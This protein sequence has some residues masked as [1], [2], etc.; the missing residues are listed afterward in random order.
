MTN[1]FSFSA[2]EKLDLSKPDPSKKQVSTN[3]GISPILLNSSLQFIESHLKSIDSSFIGFLKGTTNH[4]YQNIKQ[5]KNKDKLNNANLP[6]VVIQGN[7]IYYKDLIEYILSPKSTR[8]KSSDEYYTPNQIIFPTNKIHPKIQSIYLKFYKNKLYQCRFEVLVQINEMNNLVELYHK[9]F[10]EKS[11][12]DPVTE[13][14]QWKK[15]NY[16]IFLSSYGRTFPTNIHIIFTNLNL[17]Q[18]LWKDFKSIKDQIDK[19]L[20][21]EKK[22]PLGEL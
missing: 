5:L 16:K 3:Y 8:Q 7:R 20:S 14:Y 17:L 10:G 2:G 22:D 12:Y 15:D 1:Y 13:T 6:S 11:I 18:S 21:T 19:L 4:F 9:K